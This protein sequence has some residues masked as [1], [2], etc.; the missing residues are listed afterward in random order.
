MQWVYFSNMVVILH[1]AHIYWFWHDSHFGDIVKANWF[2]FKHAM[3]VAHGENKEKITPPL[4]SIIKTN[5]SDLSLSVANWLLTA[6]KVYPKRC[7]IWL[8]L[9]WSWKLPA[10]LYI[11]D[12]LGRKDCSITTISPAVKGWPIAIYGNF[13][14][15]IWHFSLGITRIQHCLPF[16]IEERRDSQE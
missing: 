16:E 14:K 13:W 15:Q 1:T 3:C 10:S 2:L 12:K 11:L 4:Q 6:L 9:G 7:P 5:K 8:V